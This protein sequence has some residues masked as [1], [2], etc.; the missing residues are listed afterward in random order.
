ML[1]LSSIYEV[2]IF[3]R[4]YLDTRMTMRYGGAMKRQ[5]HPKPYVPRAD[6]ARV[7]E[8]RNGSRTTPI[9]SAKVYKRKPKHRPDYA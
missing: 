2:K 1:A 9:A 8:L 3:R 4:K 7:Q 6:Y 5:Q